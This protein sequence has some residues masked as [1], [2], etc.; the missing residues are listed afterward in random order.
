MKQN[1]ALA[2]LINC[3]GQE[4]KLTLANSVEVVKVIAADSDGV[5]C[6]AASAQGEDPSNDFWIAYSAIQRIEPISN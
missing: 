5:V 6:R 2:K 1:E 4:V 3:V